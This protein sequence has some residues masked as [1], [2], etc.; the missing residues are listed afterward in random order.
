MEIRKLKK[1]LWQEE[2]RRQRNSSR[3][4]LLR[5]LLLLLL[6]LAGASLCFIFV[7]HR[8]LA[9]TYKRGEK[10]AESGSYAQS[11]RVLFTLYREHPHAAIAP[12]ALFE[13]A[14]ILNLYLGRYPVALLNYLRVERDYPDTSWALRA[15]RREA[16]IYKNSLRD[17]PRAIV[18]YQGLVEQGVPG[19]D[20]LQYQVADCYF[21]LNNFE[22]ARIE[23]DT[24]L[25]N[26]PHS[27][28]TPEAAYR[29]A[30]AYALEGEAS[31][32]AAA[33]G[34]VSRDWPQSPYALEARFGLASLLDSQGELRKA[35]GI[36]ERLK[37]SYP[38]QHA[39][40]TKIEQIRARIRKKKKAI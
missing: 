20:R 3:L 4:F 28:L 25:K 32:S 39:L 21:R 5:G 34:R 27:P 29:L 37:G 16:D 9:A 14:Q 6:A 12:R 2:R 7:Q 23:F 19:A 1:K 15:R 18:V 40:R 8:Q 35:L 33:Y 31:K 24:L 11:A 22:Q 10:L 13:S 17:Y 36:L 38:Q 30:A 26:Y